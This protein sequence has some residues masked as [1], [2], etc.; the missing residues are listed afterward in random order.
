MSKLVS[1]ILFLC[2]NFGALALGS[3]LMGSNPA[4]N[5]WYQ[6]LSK[7]PWT[8]PGAVFGAAWFTIMV[9]FSIFM[10]LLIQENHQIMLM[11]KI[12]A[13]QWVM[14]VVWNP[15]FF[16]FHLVV[17][18]FIVLVLLFLSLLYLLKV[19]RSFNSAR[20]YLVLPY[21]IWLIIAMSLN[22][23]PIFN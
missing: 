4:T 22:A 8:P 7:A 14:N 15:M 13:F 16:K 3:Y 11:I 21:L 6:N 5:E 17:A 2:L 23:Y 10:M 20:F 18:A 9:L 12:Y 1:L 19:S